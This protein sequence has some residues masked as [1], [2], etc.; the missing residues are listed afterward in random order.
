LVLVTVSDAEGL[1]YYSQATL[2]RMLR[3]T[4]PELG[5]AREQLIRAGLIVYEHPLYQV[6]SLEEAPGRAQPQV[7]SQQSLSVGEILRH[8]VGGQP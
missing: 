8:I 4:G 7:R 3:L 1:S 2:Q 5:Q 6:L